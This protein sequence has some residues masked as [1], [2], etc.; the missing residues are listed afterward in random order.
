MYFNKHNYWLSWINIITVWL[1][2]LLLISWMIA[3]GH[4]DLS[5]SRLF[6]LWSA[7]SVTWPVC[8]WLDAETA[9]SCWLQYSWRHDVIRL[10]KLV[11]YKE[12]INIKSEGVYLIRRWWWRRWI[13]FWIVH[14]CLFVCSGSFPGANHH[15]AREPRVAADHTGLW[16]LWR[17]PEEIRERQRVEVLH[18]P[19][20]LPATH[21][22]GRWTGGRG[23]PGDAAVLRFTAACS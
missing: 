6:S 11:F 4:T 20:R 22:A 21:R 23:P 16:F 14:V 17:V 18:R 8:W 1:V 19:V 5:L 2:Y 3:A 9:E 12:T 13:W 10:T 15:P 7:G